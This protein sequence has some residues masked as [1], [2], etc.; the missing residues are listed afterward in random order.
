MSN[1]ESTKS[2]DQYWYS[3]PYVISIHNQVNQQ[4]K[5]NKVVPL[6]LSE[7]VCEVALQWA[8]RVSHF[9]ELT[10]VDPETKS[11]VGTRLT[12]HGISWTVCGE[13]LAQSPPTQCVAGWM[14]SPKHRENLL[15]PQFTT[16]G[17]GVYTSGL[18]MICC[19]V[20]LSGWHGIN[21]ESKTYTQIASQTPILPNK[22][23]FLDIDL[24]DD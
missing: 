1:P 21:T 18:K 22:D 13:N 20:L 2:V 5:L 19:Q 8:E 17:L 11:E 9:P 15:N 23:R 24:L 4:R 3:H 10:H 6:L 7:S 14:K 16:E 12:Q